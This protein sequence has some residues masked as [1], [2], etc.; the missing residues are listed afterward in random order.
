MRFRSTLYRAARALG[1]AQAVAKGPGA[2]VKRAER[3]AL[4][5]FFGRIIRALVG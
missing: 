1:D 4:W 3:R 5:G 2:I